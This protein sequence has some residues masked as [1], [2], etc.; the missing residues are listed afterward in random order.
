MD[1]NFPK[2]ISVDD[3]VIEPPHVWQEWVPAKFRDQLK[4]GLVMS[5][6]QERCLTVWSMDDFDPDD[7][8]L[9]G[10]A[11]QHLAS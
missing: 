7:E 6:G 3:H 4:E 8:R 10:D 9:Q 11:G 1:I 2:I 5:R